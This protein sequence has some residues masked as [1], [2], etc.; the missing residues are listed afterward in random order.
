MAS[1][2]I[3]L[4]RHA[5]SEENRRLGSLRRC[6]T[7]LGRFT[8]PSYD[9]VAASAS[10]VNVPAQID[11]N[12]SEIGR[13]QIEQMA[14]KLKEENFVEKL[15]LVAYSPLLRAKQTSEGMLGYSANGNPARLRIVELPLLVEKTPSEWIP[16]NSGSLYQRIG[17]LKDWLTS[18]DESNI[19][20]VGHS[21]YFKAMLGLN[22]KFANCDVW[23]VKFDPEAK[24]CSHDEE[25][26]LPQGWSGLTKLYAYESP[27]TNGTN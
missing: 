2:I 16:G 8:L 23:K 13:L 21:Q 7:D 6:F 11:S 25:Y 20:L 15:D 4:I 18:Q 12:V 5:E 24:E 19:C 9:D 22:F 3:Y 27:S 26:Q 17:D 10:L 1:K 14:Q